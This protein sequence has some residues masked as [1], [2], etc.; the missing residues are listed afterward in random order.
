MSSIIR[1][2]IEPYNGNANYF[3][4]IARLGNLV[5]QVNNQVREAVNEIIGKSDENICQETDGQRH[6]LEPY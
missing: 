1:S 4:Q 6:C 2:S 5:Q 3:E